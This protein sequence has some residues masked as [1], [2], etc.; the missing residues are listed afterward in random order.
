MRSVAAS[1]LALAALLPVSIAASAFDGRGQLRTLYISGDHEDLGCL[2]SD[3]KWT[4]NED[5]CGVFIADRINEAEYYLSSEK[6]GPCGVQAA[7]FKCA[8]D[9]KPGIFR[10]PIPGHEVL[11]YSQYGVFATNAPDSPPALNAEPLAIH[12]YSGIEKGKWVWLGWESLSKVE[13]VN[14]Q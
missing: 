2:T 4:V 9:V 11:R 5:Q 7:T 14:R 8:E 1:L 10:G 3:G 13:A 12:F 6:A